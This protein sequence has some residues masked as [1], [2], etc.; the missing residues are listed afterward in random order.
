MK[1]IKEYWLN[2]V[3]FGL[4]LLCFAMMWRA[5]KLAERCDKIPHKELKITNIESTPEGIKVSGTALPNTKIK[6]IIK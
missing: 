3:V 1:F 2:F 4:M 5:I 6:V